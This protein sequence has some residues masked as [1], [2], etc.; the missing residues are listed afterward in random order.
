L[1]NGL[2]N[3]LDYEEDDIEEMFMQTFRICYKDAFGEL[4]YHDLIDNGDQITVNHFNKRVRIQ[5][6]LSMKYENIF[7]T[8]FIYHR[9]L[10]INMLISC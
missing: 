5:L 6:T 4:V 8:L 3:L 7:D 1:Y 10:W 9:N 2:K